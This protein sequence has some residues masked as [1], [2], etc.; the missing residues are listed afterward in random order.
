M[1]VDQD[2]Q[3]DDAD[4]AA[5]NAPQRK[6]GL[7]GRLLRQCVT[8]WRLILLALLVIAAAGL[9]AGLF[10]FLY[11]PDQ[12][13]NAAAERDV[14]KAAADGSV[15]LLSYSPDSL[16]RDFA[17]GRSHLTGNFLSYYSDFTQ[18]I[19]TPAAQ[20]KGLKTTANIA[21]AAVSELHPDSAVVLVFINQATMSKDK[22]EPILTASSVKVTLTKVN[23]SW[24]ISSFDPV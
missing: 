1:T 8:R 21:R 9:T 12:Q 19:V 4:E 23:G 3:A 16:D 6:V 14:I 17:A 2:S 15:A 11:R 22:P 10:F 5:Q 24:L 18:Q 7:V 20:Q 13:I